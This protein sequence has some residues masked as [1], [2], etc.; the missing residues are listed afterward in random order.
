MSLIL[1]YKLYIELELLE[2]LLILL[3]SYLRLLTKNSVEDVLLAIES[4]SSSVGISLIVVKFLEFLEFLAEDIDIDDNVT[5]VTGVG[6]VGG[7]GEVGE[8]GG[9]F[10]DTV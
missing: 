6:G 4:V 1:V 10:V 7:V 2:L 9:I 8:V 3:P 5:G